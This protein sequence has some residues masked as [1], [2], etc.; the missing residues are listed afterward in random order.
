MVKKLFVLL[1]CLVFLISC[2]TDLFDIADSGGLKSH[3]LSEPTA[4]RPSGEHYPFALSFSIPENTGVKFAVSDKPINDYSQILKLHNGI[5][6]ID[7]DCVVSAFACT[8]TESSGIV[9]YTYTMIT[10]LP[11]QPVVS[12]P[13]GA[14]VSLLLRWDELFFNEITWTDTIN[15]RELDYSVEFDIGGDGDVELKINNSNVMGVTLSAEQRSILGVNDSVL[16]LTVNVN[17]R[18]GDLI[19]PGVEKIYK[20][21]HK[22]ALTDSLIESTVMDVAETGNNFF[23]VS[24]GKELAN[25]NNNSLNIVYMNSDYTTNMNTTLQT[26]VSTEVT[27]VSCAY[28]VNSGIAFMN[29]FDSSTNIHKIYPIVDINSN[30]DAGEIQ[31]PFEGRFAFVIF[32]GSKYRMIYKKNTT[33]VYS[34]S[35]RT[36][37]LAGDLESETNLIDSISSSDR[38]VS[39]DRYDGRYLVGIEYFVNVKIYRSHI[40]NSSFQQESVFY[41]NLG[42]EMSNYSAVLGE[43]SCMGIWTQQSKYVLRFFNIITEIGSAGLDLGVVSTSKPALNFLSDKYIAMYEAESVGLSTEVF[44]RSYGSGQLG[45]ADNITSD[46]Q[47]R[48]FL[49][50]KGN[51]DNYGFWLENNNGYNQ[52]CA[53]RVFN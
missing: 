45:T 14:G 35:L 25:Q 36:Y 48:S 39:F 15:G 53:I 41:N 28:A 5:M 30:I 16:K 40:F 27:G 7:S 10:D 1:I 3:V 2:S 37:S 21:T 49:R 46:G 4:N 34:V 31:S 43:D 50:I 20:F 33:G 32:D 47:I 51:S 13:A 17:D 12:A 38:I 52:I 6:T 24:A 23:I 26:S 29:V 9:H 44:V 11:D 19:R 8:D 18:F 22:I 42:I